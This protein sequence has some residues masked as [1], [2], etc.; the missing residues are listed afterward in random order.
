MADKR[1]KPHDLK[2]MDPSLPRSSGQFVADLFVV[3]GWDEFTTIESIQESVEG[4]NIRTEQKD[5]QA[6]SRSI[7]SINIEASILDRYPSKD[8]AISTPDGIAYFCFPLGL[9]IQDVPLPPQSHSF[10]HTSEDGTRLIGCVLAFSEELTETQRQ[11]VTNMGFDISQLGRLYVRK[12]I[13]VVSRYPFISSF[14][15][16]LSKLYQQSLRASYVPI[17]RHICN[18]IDDIPAPTSGKIDVNFYFADILI[19]FQC[20]PLNEPNAWSGFPLFPLFECLSAVNIISV[21]GLLLVDRQV[22]FISS[23]F[24]LLTLCCEA[25]TSLLY[26]LRWAHA[27]IP[28]LPARLVGKLPL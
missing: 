3:V 4:E 21:F 7:F 13:S 16:F 15:K 27:Y 17:E 6:S 14:K 28:I 10:I 24:S 12:G 8:S 2:A 23:Q 19:P 5:P 20:P 9:S 25:I 11:C 1:I 26:P 18:F 22:L